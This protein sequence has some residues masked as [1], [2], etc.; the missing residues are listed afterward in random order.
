MRNMPKKVERG[1]PLHDKPYNKH[2]HCLEPLL[3]R[4]IEKDSIG[5]RRIVSVLFWDGKK[6]SMDIVFNVHGSVTFAKRPGKYPIKTKK[7]I[8]WIGF[9]PAHAG[10][11]E[12]GISRN[13]NYCIQECE[14]PAERIKEVELCSKK[15]ETKRNIWK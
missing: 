13:L 2:L 1:H 8:Y 3:K 6:A 9:D 7:S 5:K 11:F 14:N 15:V 4:V 10:D 12:N